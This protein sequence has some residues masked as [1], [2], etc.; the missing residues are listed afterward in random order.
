MVYKKKIALITGITGQDGSY[1]AEFLLKK[2][3]IV[4]GIIRRSSSF[5]TNRIEHLYQRPFKKNKNLIL[6]YGDL[7][8]SNSINQLIIKIL[9]D[10]IYNLAAQSHVAVSFDLPVYTS[11][12]NA[13][14]VLNILESIRGLIK[15]K[16]IKLY[17]AST[18]ELFGQS[19][20]KSQDELTPFYPKSPYAT[21]KL[22]ACWSVRNYR[23]SYN[24]FACNGFL[25]NHES[26]RRGGTFVTKKIINS[27][28]NIKKGSKEKLFLGNLYSLRDWGHAKD[29]VEAMWLMMQNSIPED[30]VVSTG[31]QITVKKFLE[32][33][34]AKLDIKIKWK[35]SGFNEKGYW[36]NKCIVSVNSRYFRPNEVNSLKGNSNK[37]FNKLG[38]KPKITLDDLI[39][40]M[41]Q[42][43][44]NS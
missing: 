24:I 43:Q 16:K 33:V 25:F 35:G 41:I 4:H 23:E 2:K 3:Y 34:C 9:P 7:L 26:P 21:S 18:S 42:D 8:D 19:K 36:N 11:Q 12:V 38:F 37:I 15:K 29:Y 10:E 14:G 31:K 44:I 17:Q 1:L 13:I 6:H 30:F 39:E 32:I 28:C 20:K 5:N 22:F 27:L 40:D